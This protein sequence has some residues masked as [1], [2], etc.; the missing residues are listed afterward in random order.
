MDKIPLPILDIRDRELFNGFPFCDKD[1]QFTKKSA[2]P[3]SKNP[4]K[5]ARALATTEIQPQRLQD[6]PRL[7]ASRNTA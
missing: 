2:T 3:D 6:S 7:K 4:V 5:I 1:T